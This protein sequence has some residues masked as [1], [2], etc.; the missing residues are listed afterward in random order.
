MS[1][2]RVR[3]IVEPSVPLLI[4]WVDILKALVAALRLNEEGGNHGPTSVT[5]T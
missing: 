5:H 3:A 4:P 1:D 2:H